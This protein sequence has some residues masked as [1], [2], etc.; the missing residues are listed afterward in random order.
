MLRDVVNIFWIQ[1]HTKKTKEKKRNKNSTFIYL[2]SYKSLEKAEQD[3]RFIFVELRMSLSVAFSC[4]HQILDTL[5]IDGSTFCKLVNTGSKHS[6]ESVQLARSDGDDDAPKSLFIS[7]H[8]VSFE[9][10][11]IPCIV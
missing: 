2:Q 1:H 3:L 6:Y 4:E 9:D 7:Y 10:Y 8:H 11:V 5:T